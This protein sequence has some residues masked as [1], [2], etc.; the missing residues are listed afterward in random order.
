M[1]RR[2]GGGRSIQLSYGNIF[3]CA[4]AGMLYNTIFL[5]ESQELASDRKIVYIG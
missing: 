2:L 1:S 3:S 5:K 4:V